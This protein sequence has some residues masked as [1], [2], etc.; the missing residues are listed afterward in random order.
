MTAEDI[1]STG[2]NLIGFLWMFIATRS[3]M[4]N[5]EEHISLQ[6][7]QIGVLFFILAILWSMQ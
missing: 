4:S 7:V 2:F 3:M 1:V 5:K 6:Q